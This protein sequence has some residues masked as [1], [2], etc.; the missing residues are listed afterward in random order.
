MARKNFFIGPIRVCPDRCV[1]VGPKGDQVHLE[2]RVMDVL[3]ALA[4]AS[5]EVLARRDLEDAVWPGRVVTDD[6]LTRC[7][8]QLRLALLSLLDGPND[9]PPIE[10]V[11][12]RGYRL[13]LPV[14]PVGNH[15]EGAQGNVGGPSQKSRW[16]SQPLPRI[17]LVLVSLSIAVW[18]LL[19]VVDRMESTGPNASAVSIAVLPFLNLTGDSALD[20]VADGLT[21]QLSHDLANVPGLR[22]A[23][24]TSS[25]FF[26]DKSIEVSEIAESLGVDFLV[27][28]SLRQ[29]S[30][31]RRVTVQLI[32]ADGFH[33]WSGEFNRSTEDPLRLQS[34]ISRQVLAALDWQGSSQIPELPSELIENY[35][36][37]DKYLRGRIRL[38]GSD[39]GALEEAMRL[40]RESLELDPDYARAHTGLADAWSLG[41][42]SGTFEREVATR[43]AE[44]AI[45]R[46]LELD[47]DLAEAHASRG[48]LHLCRNEYA[49][50]EAPLRIATG[51][52]PNYLNA[53]VWLGLS[54]VYQNRF[55]DAAEVYR[56][57]WQLDPM[58]AG[59]TRNFGGN[60]LLRGQ[61]DAGFSYLQ[62]AQAID[63]AN[64][65]TYR[66]LAGWQRIYG[67]ADESIFWSRQGL[68]RDSGN[69]ALLT[70]LGA[71]YLQLGDFERA[72]AQFDDAWTVDPGNPDLL[73][74]LFTL[75]LARNDLV[76][77][78]TLLSRQDYPDDR[79]R[80]ERVLSRWQFIRAL[81]DDDFMQ[82]IESAEQWNGSEALACNAF[83][84]PGARLY[85]AF[86]LR[87]AGDAAAADAIVEQCA[88]AMH[89]LRENGAEYPKLYYRSAILELLAGN[90]DGAAKALENAYARGWRE[91]WQAWNDPLWREYRERTAFRKVFEAVLEDVSTASPILEFADGSGY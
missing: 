51:R 49:E 19:S 27:E 44:E 12:K 40:F 31:E 1:L 14:V 70:E 67:R 52:N 34:D 66:M 41:I 25:F 78:D 73:S 32:E 63:P 10:T 80:Q 54:L 24:R 46:A 76:A 82:V 58:D 72:R 38:S 20:A 47:P 74:K 84:E 81:I 15:T 79:F 64:I 2:P 28:G 45:S 13:R 60:L 86:A 88:A 85:L 33:A 91:Y 90:P 23:A 21:E 83:M 30:D 89:E 7:I 3:I 11:R 6:A 71:A 43:A 62:R 59:L 39:D 29:G 48:L 16:F 4:A 18:A 26:K 55:R 56:A 42:W 53:Q 69:A 37:Y 65:A 8:Y 68:E 77:I 5:G 22:V 50:A 9:R 36:A 35:G 75:H 61:L 57:A 17:A 87:R